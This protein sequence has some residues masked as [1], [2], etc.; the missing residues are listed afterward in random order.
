M[1]VKFVIEYKTQWG[2][3]LCITGSIK[4]LGAGKHEKALQMNPVSDGLWET[5]I[6]IKE[7]EFNYHYFLKN[8]QSENLIHE[9]GDER[10]VAIDDHFK[11]VFLKDY[12]RS[13]HSIENS[14]Y[15][16]PFKKS[17]FKRESEIKN[18]IKYN[19]NNHYIRLQIRAPR[20]GAD[21]EVGVLGGVKSLGEWDEKKVIPMDGAN[22][23][24]W[25]TDIEV[26]KDDLPFEYK[27]VIVRKKDKKIVTWES[28]DNRYFLPYQLSDKKKIIIHSEENFRYPVGMWKSAGVAVPVFS[29]RTKTS[30]GVGEFADIKKLVDWSVRTGLKVIQILPVNDTAAT[31]TWVDSYPYAAI[32]IEALHPIYASL[33]MIGNLNDKKLQNQI[34]EESKRLNLLPEVDY[35]GVMKLKSKFFK[36]SFDECK[37]KFLN[38]NEL[39]NFI[40]SN[41]SWIIAYAVF[42]FF[43]DKYKTADF[44][45]WGKY[46]TITHEELIEFA[47][48]DHSHYED[49]AVHYYIQYHLD[50][51]LKDATEYA[52]KNGVVLKGDIPI[53][54]YRNSVD[55]WIS[56][57]LFNMDMQTG[58]PPDDFS[59]T[60]QNWGFPT[61][62]WEEMSKDGY[63]WWKSRMKK[64]SEYFDVFRIDHILGFFRIWEMPWEAVEGTLG[65]FNKAL[66]FHESELARWGISFDYDRFCK[67][68]IREHV[69]TGVFGN[70]TSDIKNDYLKAPVNGCFE[71]KETFNTQRKIRIHFDTLIKHS[72]EQKDFY[73]WLRNGLYRLVEEVLFLQDSSGDKLNYFNPRISFQSTYSYRDLDPYLKQ[74]LNEIYN[75][76]FY[77]RHNDFWRERAMEKLPMLRDATDMLICGEDLGMVPSSVPGVMKDL[78]ILSLAI[79]RMPSDDREFWNPKDTQYLSVTSTSSHDVSTLREWWQEDSD[80]TQRFYN[81]ILNKEGDAPYFCEPWVVTDIVKQHLQSPSMFAIFPIQDLIALSDDLRLDNPESERINIPKIINHYWKYRFHIDIEDLLEEDEFN[82]EL[83]KL[84]DEGGRLADY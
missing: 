38:S 83:R 60:G 27:F 29:L 34:V 7:S 84:I 24:I 56:P 52:R 10:K 16:S 20:V 67:P 47:S 55:A 82:D 25:K 73:V 78:Q 13:L 43:R 69:L 63:S 44:T 19:V 58:A 14:L 71:L 42:S 53:G 4:E 23:P 46:S 31:H 70:H 77:E 26:G 51:Q 62:N 41:E 54:I 1:K 45:N 40:H 72:P 48:P 3:A 32:S 64:M 76:Y 57:E 49:I 21:Y 15:T 9:F 18:N 65:H 80:Q 6:D 37:Q 59:V 28:G 5:E 81:S 35:E 17:F 36:Y 8:D 33:Q 50:K 11:I 12:W 74:K 22:Y 66:P 39:S 79:Q 2:Q 75:H 68:Y 30:S 61:Y